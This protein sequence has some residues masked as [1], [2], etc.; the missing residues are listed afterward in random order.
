MDKWETLIAS[1]IVGA[2]AI[3][4]RQHQ[5]VEHIQHAAESGVD[6]PIG[7]EAIESRV[8]TGAI[9]FSNQMDGNEFRQYRQDSRSYDPQGAIALPLTLR[10]LSLIR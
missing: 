3:Q 7:R 6:Q 2:I 5:G 4:E 8:T 9:P 1:G 10:A